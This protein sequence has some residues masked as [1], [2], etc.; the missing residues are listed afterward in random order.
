MTA[1]IP[2]IVSTKWTI[3][4]A[5]ATREM[6]NSFC[7]RIWNQRVRRY[8][9]SSEHTSTT[10][11]TQSSVNIAIA[12]NSMYRKPWTSWLIPESSSSRIES[13]S[14]VW[15]EMIRPD[16]YDSWNSRLSFWVCR[17]TRL[18]RSIRIAWLMRALSTVYQAMSPAPITPVIR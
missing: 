9:G 14:L 10:P 16:V 2:V 12:M 18:R 4:F 13:R 3:S 11:L 15:R 1:R 8:S 17:K 6:R 5:E 7:E